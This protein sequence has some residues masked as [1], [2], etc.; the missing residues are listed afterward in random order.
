M[1]CLRCKC[2]SC[3]N[4]VTCTYHR[5]CAGICGQTQDYVKSCED[6]VQ[7]KDI[8]N[9]VLKYKRLKYLEEQRKKMENKK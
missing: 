5:A 7:G 9:P 2:T 1:E 3:K 8:I 4:I 6:Y